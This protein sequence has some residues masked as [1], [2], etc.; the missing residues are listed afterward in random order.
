MKITRL[1]SVIV[2]LSACVWLLNAQGPGGF[3]GGGGKGKGK[4]GPPATIDFSGYWTGNMQEDNAERGAGPDLVDYGGVPIN[5]AGRL[6]AL[7]YDTSRL[8]SR[9]HQCDGYVA[10]YS[11]RSIGNTRVWEER[12]PRLHTLI[13][14]HWFSQTFEGHRVFWMDG[15]AHPPAYA[16]HT[17]MGFSTGTFVG[18]ALRVETTHLKQGWLRRN[19][20]PESDQTTLTEFFTR[21]GDHITYTSVINDPVFLSEPWIK[22]TDFYRQPTDPGSWLFPCDDSEQVTGR[23]PDQVPNYLFG[24]HPYIDEYAKKN[25]LALLGALGGPETLYAE[26]EAKV[27]AATPAEARARTL[28]T[29]GPSQTSRAVDPDPRDGEIHVLPVRDGVYMLVGDGG[30]IVVQVGDEG[31]FVVDTGAGQLTD[32]VLAAIR[33]LS[34][35]PIQFVANTNFHPAYTG[36]N[37]KLKKAGSDP[38]VI[39]TF[40]AMSTPGVGSTATIIAHE[41]VAGRMN[42]SMGNPET[43]PDSWPLDTYMSDRLR[44][45]HNGDS[46][47]LFYVPNASTDGDSL[48]HFRRADVIV[49]GDVFNTTQYPFIDVANGGSVQG[50]ID[51]L[52]AILART[53]F[54][55]SGEG[56][57]Y[58]VPGRGYLC[59]EHEVVEYRDMMAIIRDRIKAMIGS[60]ATV[61]QVKAAKVTAD[62]DTRYGANTGAWT[63]EKF[64]EAMYTSLKAPAAKK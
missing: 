28:P 6:W 2:S 48:I 63:T 39:G 55:H 35:K 20:L 37:E 18:N 45:F 54:Q 24:T 3:G 32:K 61:A 12:D 50:E 4:A 26:F 36:G 25:G 58:I 10:P 16:P 62:Y 8:T 17:W 31:A 40:L 42:G 52:D 59:D 13:A 64:V 11:V 57:T 1:L 7:S 60:G 27:T 21:R 49:T 19:G 23:A 14:I 46:I 43:S 34:P 30:N 38:S 29:P 56:G 5:E 33:R 44:R 9:F 53:V 51:A 15:R 41:N 22:T 47:E